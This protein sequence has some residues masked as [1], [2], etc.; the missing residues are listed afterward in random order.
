MSAYEQHVEEAQ[1]YPLLRL[2][3]HLDAEAYLEFDATLTKIP[4][5]QTCL[6][7]D[8]RG[9]DYMESSPIGLLMLLHRNL[10]ARGGA[11]VLVC[12]QAEVLRLLE[13][14]GVAE[15]FHM[16]DTLDEG[17]AYLRSIC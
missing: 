2:T 14:V 6:V 8:M 12:C 1:G 17:V 4:S 7:I 16:F 15:R 3:G 5:S 9:V 11:L 13:Q 10:E